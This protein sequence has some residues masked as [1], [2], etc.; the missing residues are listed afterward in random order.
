MNSTSPPSVAR[1]LPMG[2][3]RAFVTLLVLAHHSVIAYLGQ[4]PPPPRSLLEGSL[5]WS[6]FPVVDRD[7]WEPLGILVLFND[8][9]FMS[10]MFFLSGLFVWSSLERKGAGLFLRDRLGRL[11]LPFLASV[12]FLAP[13]AYYPTYRLTGAD[14]SL[15]AFARTWIQLPAWPA[16]PAWFLWVLVVFAGVAAALY[17][18]RPRWGE[19][20][21]IFVEGRPGKLFVRLILLG[22]LAYIPLSMVVPYGDWVHWGPFTVQGSRF[23]HYGLYFFVGV[24]VG[25]HGLERGLLTPDGELARRWK[26]WANLP[27]IGFGAMIAVLGMAYSIKG[28]PDHFWNV[29]GG[30]VFEFACAASCFALISI[31]VRLARRPW[32][33]FDILAQNAYGMFLVHYAFTTW[34]QYALLGIAL[35]GVAKG[36]IVFVV[37][38]VASGS[39]TSLL[40]RLPFLCRIL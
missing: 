17:R 30:L 2:Y 36:L 35:P 15:A 12:L 37:V 24:A 40:R 10:L 11:G 33:L 23:L 9:Y 8:L 16:G 6:A 39:T 1:N 38:V 7:K 13:L 14:P 21:A 19:R 26:G 18:L 3:L 4:A 32:R 25:A 31:F 29:V 5:A 28:L 34:T 22:A 27:W 20:L